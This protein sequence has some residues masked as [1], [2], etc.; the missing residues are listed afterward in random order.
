M[1]RYD[2]YQFLGRIWLFVSKHRSVFMG[3]ALG[4]LVGWVL[5]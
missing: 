3:L 1:T 5:S 4:A 2:F